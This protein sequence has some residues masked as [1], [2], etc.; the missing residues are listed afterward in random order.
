MLED[1]Q[2]SNN[3]LGASVE[4]KIWSFESSSDYSFDSDRIVVSNGKAL[5]KS[6][7]Q[8]DDDNTTNGFGGGTNSETQ[9][10]S[11]QNQLE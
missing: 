9:W 4:T 3:V 11:T 6:F 8:D 5:I 1:E 2:E 7:D 10:N